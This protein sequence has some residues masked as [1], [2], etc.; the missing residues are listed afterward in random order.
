MDRQLAIKH[1]EQA[2]RHVALGEKHITRQRE[3]IAQMEHGG[4][5]TATAVDLLRI[6]ELVQ[7][8]HVADRDRIRAELAN[9]VCLD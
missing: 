9:P 2:E 1:L 6:F 8:N 7:Q 4:H 5:D 3:L